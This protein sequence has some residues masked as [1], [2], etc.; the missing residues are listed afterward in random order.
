MVTYLFV[1]NFIYLLYLFK[2]AGDSELGGG[3]N[4]NCTMI[5]SAP[6]GG[7]KKQRGNSD[8][9]KSKQ[10]LDTSEEHMFQGA[11]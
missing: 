10:K 9:V 3:V 6:L 1:L 2:R 7:L 5:F 4:L 11:V 8:Q